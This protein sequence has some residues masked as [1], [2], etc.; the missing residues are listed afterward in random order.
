MLVPCLCLVALPKTTQL[1]VSQ[2]CLDVRRMK[3]LILTFVLS[4]TL[5]GSA[6]VVRVLLNHKRN[7]S[8]PV[9]SGNFHNF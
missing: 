4:D 7:I 6:V 9:T 2:S 5:I 1:T 8:R 3:N